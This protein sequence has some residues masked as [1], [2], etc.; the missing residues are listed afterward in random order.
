MG[1][2]WWLV[3]GIVLSCALPLTY[4]YAG[5]IAVHPS[6]WVSTLSLL[7]QFNP[8]LSWFFSYNLHLLVSI[9]YPLNIFVSLF[10][11]VTTYIHTYRHMHMFF[12]NS[13]IWE[14]YVVVGKAKKMISKCVVCQ[15]LVNIVLKSK[16]GV[17]RKGKPS[18]EKTWEGCSDQVL[19][20]P[21][22][23]ALP[24]SHCRSSM[25]GFC[26]DLCQK[27]QWPPVLFLLD[28]SVAFESPFQLFLRI[29]QLAHQVSKW[30][31]L[32]LTSS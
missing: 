28:W 7:S 20:A 17:R 21:P 12:I 14:I 1:L 31:C 32:L 15:M 29:L 10:F 30:C 2:P 25:K 11:Y 5:W 22:L 8:C 24:F 23:P 27:F 19:P 18:P 13:L 3:C 9:Y 6:T 26:G 4:C 16:S